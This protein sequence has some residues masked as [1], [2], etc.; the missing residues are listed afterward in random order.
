MSHPARLDD[1]RTG[2]LAAGVTVPIYDTSSIDQVHWILE[3]N[4]ASLAIVETG[5][6]PGR[7]RSAQLLSCEDAVVDQGRRRAAP[8]AL[9][10]TTLVDTRVAE[11]GLDSLRP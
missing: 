3:N 8:A 5:A 4:E 9:R 11:L 6:W 2:I 10:S 1:P 7:H